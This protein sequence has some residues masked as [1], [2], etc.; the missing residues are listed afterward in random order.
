MIGAFVDPL[1]IVQ[2]CGPSTDWVLYVPY[3][4]AIGN[5]A[6]VLHPT[7]TP[8]RPPSLPSPPNCTVLVVA[9]LGANGTVDSLSA[10]SYDRLGRV[11]NRQSDSDADGRWDTEESYVYDDVSGALVRVEVS[12]AGIVVSRTVYNVSSG[13]RL[14]SVDVDWDADGVT[15]E[16]VVYRYDRAGRAVSVD[17]VRPSRPELWERQEFGYDSVGRLVSEVW[18][19][20]GASVGIRRIWNA[21]SQVEL[22]FTD[23]DR[24][25]LVDTTERYSYGSDGRLRARHV[26]ESDPTLPDGMHEYEYDLAAS[27]LKR[28]VYSERAAVRIV[29]DYSYDVSNRRMSR[30]DLWSVSRGR[31][32]R[33]YR[34]ACAQPAP[35]AI[36]GIQGQRALPLTLCAECPK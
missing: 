26:D 21:A 6:P 20:Q 1:P 31:E 34:Y 5:Q 30:E 25:G 16:R 4:G 18:C 7:A 28:Y 10:A 27:S 15:D 36:T 3:V 29:E 35:I 13:G 8:P 23:I 19:I 33:S 22:E 14:D 2:A 17:L 12:R 11:F 9:D 24:D 32:I